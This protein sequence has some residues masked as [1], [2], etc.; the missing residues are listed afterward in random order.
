M[1]DPA[2]SPAT[3]ERRLEA[4]INVVSEARRAVDAGNQVDLSGLEREVDGLCKELGALPAEAGD[5]LKPALVAL[6]DD[7]DRLTAALTSA[8]KKLAEDIG[9][10]SA[11]R[12]ANKAYGQP[13]D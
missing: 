10:L 4:A 8:H 3:L 7:L 5:K 13:Q 6:A 2:S 9:A 1:T 12:R 11:R